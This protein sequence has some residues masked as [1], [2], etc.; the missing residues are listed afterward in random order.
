LRMATAVI[1]PKFGMA[2]E[3]A[4]IVRWYKQEGEQVEQGEP[5]LEVM[6]DKVN[7]DV[8]APA[9]GVLLTAKYQVD[10][11]VPVTIVIGYIGEPGEEIP[12]E[13]PQPMPGQPAKAAA[14]SAAP[15]PTQKAASGK[16]K[17]TPAARRLA[18]D[19]GIELSLVEGTGPD[20]VIRTEDVEAFVPPEV[21]VEGELVPL[22]GV[23]KV[24][25]ERMAT[26]WREAPHISFTVTIDMT[27]AEVR[28]A[29]WNEKRSGGEAKLSVTGL[30]IKAVA[31][32][33]PRHPYLN[34]SF[35]GEEV[36]LH[37][38]VNVGMAV[39]REE[40]LIVPVLKGADGLSLEEIAFQCSDLAQRARTGKLTPDDVVGGT[41]TVSNLGMFGVE[42]FNAI[43]NPP[44]SAILAVGTLGPEPVVLDESVVVRQ[45]MKITLS[46]DHRIADGALAGEFLGDLKRSLEEVE[47]GLG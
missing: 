43:I 29:A 42:Q 13:Q 40:G 30:L 14:V 7:M 21:P 17:A 1:M 41:F 2:Q 6:T 25:A 44:E 20:G 3:Q 46:V 5:L 27:E 19:R 26:S 10:D 45:R 11:V 12:E 28:R 37:K 34:A 16:A 35:R 36:L 38:Q 33:L 39:A 47:L 9:S 15:Q 24:I 32:L 8:E 18:R 22:K 31:D 23:R 4:T